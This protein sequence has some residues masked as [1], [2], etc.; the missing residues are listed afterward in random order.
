MNLEAHLKNNTS[1]KNFSSSVLESFNGSLPDFLSL[2][3]A[4]AICKDSGLQPM[5]KP[6]E[7]FK[8]CF[9]VYGDL[10]GKVIVESSKK[11]S[12]SNEILQESINIVL[13]HTVT[14]LQKFNINC[15]FGTASL[16][17]Q[18][19][20]LKQINFKVRYSVESLKLKDELIL[21]FVLQDDF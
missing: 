12:F 2:Y 9:E 7:N 4:A 21:S 15:L 19:R 13:G 10:K 1:M 6:V 17:C 18:D 16:N 8:F 11:A 14:Q 5:L 20:S 3:G